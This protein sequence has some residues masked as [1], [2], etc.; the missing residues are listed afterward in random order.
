MK[1]STTQP[2]R[3]FAGNSPLVLDLMKQRGVTRN[4]AM[5]AIGAPDEFIL[6]FIDVP[7]E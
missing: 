2:V 7:S 1:I 6:R 3:F 4:T 5:V